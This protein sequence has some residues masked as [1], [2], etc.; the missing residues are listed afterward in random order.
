MAGSTSRSLYRAL[1]RL[2]PSGFRTRFA[3]EML[4]IFDEVAEREGVVGLFVDIFLSLPGN[5]R[6]ASP[7]PTS[8]PIRRQRRNYSRGIASRCPPRPCRSP[9][10]CKAVLS[11]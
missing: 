1:L 6:C 9:G 10:W 11:L 8:R 5:G 7:S 2:H 3:D 4:W